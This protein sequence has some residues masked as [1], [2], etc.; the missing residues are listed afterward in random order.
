MKKNALLLAKTAA[1]I[2]IPTVLTSS[3]EEHAQGPLLPELAEIL[4]K[5]F[6]NRIKR[7]GIVNAM[8]DKNFADAVYAAA[9]GRKRIIVA[10]VTNDVCTVYPT[11]TLL[12]QGYE[13]QVVADA[14][15]SPTKEG[16]ELS[17]RRMEKQAQP[18]S[19]P[20][21]CSPNWRKT[22]HRVTARKSCR[23]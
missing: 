12:E 11:L 10:G 22:G 6:E 17:L 21:N 18:W 20:T 13:A 5:E 7:D 1:A 2:G 19:A 3:M 16:D 15:G 9:N 8:A 14:G 4:P 23:L